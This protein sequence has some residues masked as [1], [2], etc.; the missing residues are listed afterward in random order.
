[1]GNKGHVCKIVH[2]Q[3]RSKRVDRVDNLQGPEGPGRP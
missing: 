1:M 2:A 3:G